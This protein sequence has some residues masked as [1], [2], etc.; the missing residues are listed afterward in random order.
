MVDSEVTRLLRVGSLTK[1]TG[2]GLTPKKV[3]KIL[4]Q[5]FTNTLCLLINMYNCASGN[6]MNKC[7]AKCPNAIASNE[8]GLLA[9][10]YKECIH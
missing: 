5:K 6:G 4:L 3:F 1:V 8:V 7:T 2:D 10:Q 9:S